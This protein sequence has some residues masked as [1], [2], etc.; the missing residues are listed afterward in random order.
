MPAPLIGAALQIGGK[1]ID[2]LFPDPVKRAEAQAMLLTLENQ[3]KLAEINAAM[4]VIVA[5]AQS[6]SWITRSWRP[7]IML[8]FGVI[9]A[10]NY[11]LYP[12]LSLFWPDAPAL[13]LPPDLW[14]LMKIGLG[15]YVVG[16][17]AE[18]G[19]KAWKK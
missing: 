10:N 11:I 19:I 13:E 1:L 16:R 5:E 18:Q 17:S 15:G 4:N 6:D 14:G 3:G 12:Y 2:A 7:I 9:V 8:M